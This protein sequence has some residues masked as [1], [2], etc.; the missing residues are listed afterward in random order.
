MSFGS[1]QTDVAPLIYCRMY[2][3][4]IIKMPFYWRRRCPTADE[5][6]ADGSTQEYAD[7][8]ACVSGTHLWADGTVKSYIDSLT[9]R[10]E[11]CFVY[12]DWP[13]DMENPPASAQEGA[14]DPRSLLGSKVDY[15]IVRECTEYAVACPTSKLDVEIV[16]G[17]HIMSSYMKRRTGPY[18]VHEYMVEVH[19]EMKLFCTLTV[20]VDEDCGLC[21]GSGEWTPTIEVVDPDSTTNLQC[22]CRATDKLGPFTPDQVWIQQPD[23]PPTLCSKWTIKFR[24]ECFDITDDADDPGDSDEFNDTLAELER[25]QNEGNISDLSVSRGG[26]DCIDD[27]EAGEAPKCCDSQEDTSLDKCCES[28]VI[29][30]WDCPPGHD[31]PF[32]SGG[33]TEEEPLTIVPCEDRLVNEKNRVMP[34]VNMLQ[35]LCTIRTSRGAWLSAQY[36]DLYTVEVGDNNR[37]FLD[38]CIDPA[39]GDEQPATRNRMA[40]LVYGLGQSIYGA[41]SEV[42]LYETQAPVDLSPYFTGHH[43]WKT[44][45]Q[46]A[47]DFHKHWCYG[48]HKGW[49]EVLDDLRFGLCNALVCPDAA[50]DFGTANPGV[51]NGSAWRMLRGTPLC[52]RFEHRDKWG[53][54]KDCWNP[55]NR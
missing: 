3:R 42:M 2:T 22:A 6:V 48:P 14:V 46:E 37:K 4:Y 30:W 5:L 31:H 49:E 15:E 44:Y 25:E 54:P 19:S 50:W 45:L 47:T 39:G 21:E 1:T 38:F 29:T 27:G 11:F 8:H 43:N 10:E 7:N 26:G 17:P 12:R 52:S 33:L 36:I 53:D 35:N 24:Q 34:D 28:R 20:W 9:R 23:G 16:D 32:T 55:W 41:M 40:N 13:H 51:R 18:G